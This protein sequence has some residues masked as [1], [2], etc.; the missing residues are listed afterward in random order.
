MKIN[1][2]F[3]QCTYTILYYTLVV[4]YKYVVTLFS[5]LLMNFPR[6]ISFSLC[7]ITATILHIITVFSR[8]FKRC[9][10]V[11]TYIIVNM[12][13][14]QKMYEFMQLKNI[15]YA[16]EFTQNLSI[17]NFQNAFYL[18]CCYIYTEYIRRCIYENIVRISFSFGCNIIL[19]I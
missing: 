9:I 8:L 2:F 18:L 15:K 16:M 17:S 4:M 14:V 5:T 12:Y 7:L 1:L 6:I 19:I 10:H 13:T 11:H 3:L